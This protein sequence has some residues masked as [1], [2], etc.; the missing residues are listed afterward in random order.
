MPAT[1][2]TPTTQTLCHAQKILVH[3]RVP[4]K[5]SNNCALPYGSPKRAQI[6]VVFHTGPQKR[7]QIIFRHTH[8]YTIHFPSLGGRKAAD[9]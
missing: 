7:A 6:I 2:C 1:Y 4:K 8:K 5:S 3:I 9:A